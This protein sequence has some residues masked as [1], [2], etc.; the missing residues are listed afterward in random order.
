[1]TVGPITIPGKPA[2]PSLGLPRAVFRVRPW[3]QWL[4]LALGVAMFVGGLALVFPTGNHFW[5]MPLDAIIPIT[6]GIIGLEA[7]NRLRRSACLIVGEHG[8]DD[9]FA[10]KGPILWRDVA[11]MDVRQTSRR[12][13]FEVIVR[14]TKPGGG[15]RDHR[16]EVSEL[17]GKAD[18]S[19]IAALEE[20]LAR[21]RERSAGP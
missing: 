20:S 1:M 10:G 15:T 19:V 7:A 8:F 12:K 9:R 17:F 5:G 3:P 16:I 13:T 21:E 14:V 2:D 6:G 11:G 18:Q 4:Q